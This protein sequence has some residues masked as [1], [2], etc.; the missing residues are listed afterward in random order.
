MPRVASNLQD[1]SRNREER[2]LRARRVLRNTRAIFSKR[3]LQKIRI[4]DVCVW[5]NATKA[6]PAFCNERFSEETEFRVGILAESNSFLRTK[7][8]DATPRSSYNT[9][10]WISQIR[11]QSAIRIKQSS[12]SRA[13]KVSGMDIR[14]WRIGTGL[15]RVSDSRRSVNRGS[16]QDRS[17]S[18]LVSRKTLHQGSVAIHDL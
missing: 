4:R 18:W 16:A 8:K 13:D 14:V 15:Y 3:L 5:W 2:R 6:A 1:F 17:R 11:T 9:K 12:R 10:S 7:H